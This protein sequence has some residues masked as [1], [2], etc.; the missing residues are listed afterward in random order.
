MSRIRSRVHELT[1]RRRHGG[2]DVR[3]VIRALNPVLRGWSNYFRTGNAHA[4]FNQVDHYVHRR[5]VDW[6]GRRGGQRRAAFRRSDG[7]L[8]RLHEMGLYRLRGTVRYPAQATPLRPSVSRV[9][10]TGMHGLKGGSGNGSASRT[11][12]Q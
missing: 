4:K 7:T 6:M 3:E 9:R 8:D 11:P 5:V 12:R 2:K 10:E 1:D